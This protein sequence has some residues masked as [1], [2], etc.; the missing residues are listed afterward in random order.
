MQTFNVMLNSTESDPEIISASSYYYIFNEVLKNA[1]SDSEIIF[2]SSYYYIKGLFDM[3]V[4]AGDNKKYKFT[5]CPI[6]SK[7]ESNK[8]DY[9]HYCSIW[10]DAHIM[11]VLIFRI[12]IARNENFILS[13]I[14]ENKYLLEKDNIK[15]NFIISGRSICYKDKLY[16]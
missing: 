8:I 13:D 6:Y 1:E 12:E 16:E 5:I 7:F 4:P 9:P 2:A 10:I 11:E 15:L 3:T 14:N